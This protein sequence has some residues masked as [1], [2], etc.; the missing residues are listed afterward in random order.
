MNRSSQ[1]R[2]PSAPERLEEHNRSEV[3]GLRPVGQAAEEVV[4]DRAGVALVDLGKRTS[5]AARARFPK[6]VVA[7]L[8]IFGHTWLMSDGPEEF[9][10]LLAFPH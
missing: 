2:L 6:S 3:L 10:G 1:S 7:R 8:E 4:V 9:H 5:V